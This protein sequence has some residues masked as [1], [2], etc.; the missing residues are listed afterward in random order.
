MND[1]KEKNP[2]KNLNRANYFNSRIMHYAQIKPFSKLN[3]SVGGSG[4]VVNATTSTHGPSE[5]IIVEMGNPIKAWHTYPGGQSGNPGNPHYTY[6]LDSW[7]SGEYF[8]VYF[9][10]SA[11]DHKDHTMF[12]QSLIPE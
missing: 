8:P 4:D 7:S 12:T 1:W 5:R 2:G 11:N 3:L 10:Q 9:Y 6:F